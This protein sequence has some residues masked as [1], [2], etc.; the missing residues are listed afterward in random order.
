MSKHNFQTD[1]IRGIDANDTN[2][3]PDTGKTH[4]VDTIEPDD[5]QTDYHRG[6]ADIMRCLQR[7]LEWLWYSKTHEQRHN[8]MIGLFFN[9]NMEYILNERSV[10]EVAHA[11][12]INRQYLFRVISETKAITTEH[13]DRPTYHIP[14][15]VDGTHTP[16]MDTEEH[17]PDQMDLFT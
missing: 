5:A 14:Q 13:P 1:Y 11:E 15:P 16:H 10:E 6:A 17:D 12:S 2:T 9:L 4:P 3:I 8:R 7:S